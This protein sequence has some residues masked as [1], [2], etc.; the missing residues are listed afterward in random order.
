MSKILIVII[1]IVLDRIF[2]KTC[3]VLYKK[4]ELPTNILL[5]VLLAVH[6]GILVYAIYDVVTSTVNTSDKVFFTLFMC[7]AIGIFVTIAVLTW[8]RWWKERKANQEDAL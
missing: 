8:K 1:V 2:K 5:T 3:P 6:C 7:V 4:L